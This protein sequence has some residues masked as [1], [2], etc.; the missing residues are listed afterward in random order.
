[1]HRASQ[2]KL[3]CR[4]CFLCVEVSSGEKRNLDEFVILSLLES[5][6]NVDISVERVILMF[7][8]ISLSVS[9]FFV[10]MVFK[11]YFNK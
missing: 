1:M 9:F 5:C 3:S 4:R 2:G 7:S 11:P 8:R 10:D 6:F